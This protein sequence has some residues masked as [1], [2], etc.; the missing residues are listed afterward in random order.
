MFDHVTLNREKT[1]S[2][3]V[4]DWNTLPHFS[5]C[6]KHSIPQEFKS[7]HS[8][9]LTLTMKVLPQAFPSLMGK[10]NLTTG[11]ATDVSSVPRQSAL[12]QMRLRISKLALYPV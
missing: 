6:P 3:R 8:T 4:S 10:L 5:P 1:D 12:F 11:G 2:N 9:A 7:G